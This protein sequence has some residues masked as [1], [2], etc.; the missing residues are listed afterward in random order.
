L[1]DHRYVNNTFANADNYSYQFWAPV[2][3]GWE[4]GR[5]L[6]DGL[7]ELGTRFEEQT[8]EEVELIMPR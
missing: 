1:G 7:K 5:G 4:R 3:T 6:I 8:D 2:V